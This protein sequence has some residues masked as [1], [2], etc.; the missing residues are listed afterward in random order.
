[1]GVLKRLILKFVRNSVFCHFLV[2]KK[3]KLWDFMLRFSSVL[4]AISKI[5]SVDAK[6]LKTHDILCIDL[7]DVQDDVERNPSHVAIFLAALNEP[8]SLFLRTSY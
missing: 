8:D 3:L 2:L 1:M 5:N 7:F 4:A 6:F